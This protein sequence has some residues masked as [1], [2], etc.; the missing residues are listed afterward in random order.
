MIKKAEFYQK[1]E[2]KMWDYSNESIILM[3]DFKGM[4]SVEMERTIRENI[5][6]EGKLSI[7]FFQMVENFNLHN[8]WRLKHPNKKDYTYFLEAKKIRKQN[9]W[10]LRIQKTSI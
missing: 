9:R 8:T 5:S 6:K 3:G 2:E 1:L 10:D 4:T 7:S